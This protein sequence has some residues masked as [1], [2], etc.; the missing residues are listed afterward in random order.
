VAAEIPADRRFRAEGSVQLALA[1]WCGWPRGTHWGALSRKEQQP[2]M[3]S[4]T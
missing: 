1:L 2:R 3:A 4:T